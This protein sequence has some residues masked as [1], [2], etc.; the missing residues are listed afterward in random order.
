MAAR[1]A[2]PAAASPA[3]RRTRSRPGPDG[4]VWWAEQNDD[5]DGAVGALFDGGSITRFPDEITEFSALADITPGAGVMW[6][7]E[8]G[9]DTIG[10]ISVATGIVREFDEGI[11]NGEPTG[12]A[13]GPD[14]NVWFTE[15]SSPGAIA[16]FV[17]A[18]QAITEFTNGLTPDGA[19]N[20]IVAGPNG[21]LWFTTLGAIG[22]I[23][24]GGVITEHRAGIPPDASPRQLTVG[25]DGAIWFTDESDRIGRFDIAARLGHDV[26]R[27]D[28]ARRHAGRDRGR[29]RRRD[30]VHAARHGPDR[31]PDAARPRPGAH[32]HAHPRADGD[33]DRFTRTDPEPPAATAT[34]RALRHDGAH[35]ERARRRS[36]PP[37]RPEPQRHVHA[38]RERPRALHDPPARGE[39]QHAGVAPDR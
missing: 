12:I 9:F 36:L 28:H 4:R 6:F 32:P 27:R 22:Q 15:A 20:D 14:G 23:T 25:P 34:R 10:R 3:R 31:P 21:S 37:R 30:L 1:R 38:V 29:P 18:T 2:S 11:T 19:P 5:G 39:P 17:P 13:V 35:R 16:R 26:R 7:T 24:I 33:P 8:S